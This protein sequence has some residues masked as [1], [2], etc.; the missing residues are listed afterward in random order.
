[1]KKIL[2]LFFYFAA[3]ALTFADG[4]WFLAPSTADAHAFYYYLPQPPLTPPVCETTPPPAQRYFYPVPSAPPV[5]ETTPPPVY[6][7]YPEY[8]GSLAARFRVAVTE[9]YS[10]GGLVA[11]PPIFWI[12]HA[13]FSVYSDGTVVFALVFTNGT[14]VEYRLRNP[15]LRTRHGSSMVKTLYSNVE[16]IGAYPL[17]MPA[18]CEVFSSGRSIHEIVLRGPKN[19]IV[20][21]N[22]SG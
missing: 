11:V 10:T 7:V 12:S 18:S 9:C 19:T 2:P 6:Y 17:F 3:A 13:L 15:I 14:A 4:Y 22:F 16:T 20:T 21:V 8:P 5:R 1:M